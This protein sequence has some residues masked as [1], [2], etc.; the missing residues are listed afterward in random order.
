VIART[1]LQ[2]HAHEVSFQPYSSTLISSVTMAPPL[3]ALPQAHIP[4]TRP[5]RIV[6]GASQV[7]TPPA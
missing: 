4:F 2:S 6:L 7:W 3:A 5:D 1:D